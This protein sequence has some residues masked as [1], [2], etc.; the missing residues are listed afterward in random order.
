MLGGG[1]GRLTFVDA[2]P[3][4]SDSAAAEAPA[5]DWLGG[6]WGLGCLFFLFLFNL[7]RYLLLSEVWHFRTPETRRNHY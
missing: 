5:G 4:A 6:G 1:G 7:P 2:A 3:L